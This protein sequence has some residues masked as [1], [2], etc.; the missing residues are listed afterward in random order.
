MVGNSRVPDVGH[1][2]F[3]DFRQGG[4][5]EVVKLS[6][7]ILF[8]GAPRNV[9]GVCIAKKSSEYLVNDNLLGRHGLGICSFGSLAG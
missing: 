4:I 6:Y 2:Q 7:S 1:A 5:R 8:F 9:A 3:F